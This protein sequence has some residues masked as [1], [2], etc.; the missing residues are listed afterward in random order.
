[1]AQ[2]E[3]GFVTPQI[4]PR[5]ET[6]ALMVQRMTV[7]TAQSTEKT[8]QVPAATGRPL[9]QACETHVDA[10][11]PVSS[12]KMKKPRLKLLMPMYF[13]FIVALAFDPERV[14]SNDLF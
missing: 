2:M 12:V 11:W 3:P 7:Q 5:P 9:T 13:M 1:M 10:W 4:R 8:E 14:R 6:G